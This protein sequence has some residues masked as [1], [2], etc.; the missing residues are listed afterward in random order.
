MLVNIKNRVERTEYVK[1]AVR[2]L[3]VDE[4]LLWRELREPRFER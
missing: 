2:E 1:Y 4:G 3:N